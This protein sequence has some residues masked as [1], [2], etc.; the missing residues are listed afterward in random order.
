MG[1]IPQRLVDDRL[2]LPGVTDGRRS[3]ASSEYA[4][5]VKLLALAEMDYDAL[6]AE[7]RRLYRPR[8]PLRRL[9]GWISVS[10]M[11]YAAIGASR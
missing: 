3:G 1:L 10:N 4:V 9:A 8:H 6:R 5:A 11:A 7:W 2:V